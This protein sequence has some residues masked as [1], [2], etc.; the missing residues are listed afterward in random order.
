MCGVQS[1]NQSEQKYRNDNN[2]FYFLV[3]FGILMS[4][5]RKEVPKG[6]ACYDLHVHVYIIA[7][8]DFYE[9]SPNRQHCMKKV[10]KGN[11]VW[12]KSQ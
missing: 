5:S 3:Y 6:N 8:W 1:V 4:S 12:K 2:R 10:L 9:R 7:Y 11:N